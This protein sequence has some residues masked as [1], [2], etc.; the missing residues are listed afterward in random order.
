MGDAYRPGSIF[1]LCSNRGEVASEIDK[2]APDAEFP[3]QCGE[4]VCAYSF[5]MP[6]KSISMFAG[7][8]SVSSAS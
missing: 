1:W 7:I 8:N 6:P 3:R 4:G 5:T 2:T